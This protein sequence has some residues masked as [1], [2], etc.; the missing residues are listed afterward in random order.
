MRDA[1]DQVTA[2]LPT[3]PPV[4]RAPERPRRLSHAQRRELV[5]YTSPKHV[6]SCR[7][8][9]HVEARVSSPDTPFERD[10]HGCKRH[11][12]PVLLGAICDD[13]IGRKA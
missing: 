13:F 4:P 3:F 1:L 7:T 12:F 11:R 5:G 6:E 2:E 10:S 8:C 9:K